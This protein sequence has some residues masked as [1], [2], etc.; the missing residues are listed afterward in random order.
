MGK[1]GVQFLGGCRLL[2][3]KTIDAYHTGYFYREFTFTQIRHQVVLLNDLINY[4][5][6]LVS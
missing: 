5:N 2:A 1:G 4:H 3:D 6:N